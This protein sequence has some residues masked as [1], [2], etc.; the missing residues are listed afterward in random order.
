VED[1]TIIYVCAKCGYQTDN[2]HE[3][4]L[5]RQRDCLDPVINVL[6]VQH[7]QTEIEKEACEVS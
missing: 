4:F 7:Q 2:G 3:A 1:A 5:H 6:V